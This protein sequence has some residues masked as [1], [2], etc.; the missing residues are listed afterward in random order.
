MASRSPEKFKG[1]RGPAPHRRVIAE[2]SKAKI[3]FFY[4]DGDTKFRAVKVCIHPRR[5][6]RMEA[7]ITELSAKVKLPFGVRSIFTP[8]GR[9]MITSLEK[10]ENGESYICSPMRHQARGLDTT[11]VMPPPR[12]YYDKPPSGTKQL[13]HLL[14]EFEFEDRSRY[15]G[16]RYP[17]RDARM[18]DAYNRAQP[19]KITVLKN[20]EPTVHHVVLINRRTA[21]MFEQILSDISGMFSMAVRKLYTVEGRRISNLSAMIN[22]PDVLVAAGREP[23]R[24]LAGFVHP[25]QDK[26][27]RMRTRMDIN[28][29]LNMRSTMDSHDDPVASRLKKRRDRLMKTKGNWKVWCT[30]NELPTAGTNAQVTITVYGHKGNTGPVPLGFP[31]K[32][33][34][35]PGQVDEFDLSMGTSIGEIYKI[36]VGHDNSGSSPEWFCDEV[37]MQD[38]DTSEMLVFPCRRWMSRDE[39]DHE[40]CREMPAIRKGEPHLPVIKYEVSVLTGD[41]W[42]AGTEANVYLTIYGDRGDSGVRQLYMAPGGT[43]RSESGGGPFKKGQTSHFTVEAVSLGHLKR[44]IVGHDGTVPG[45]GWYLERMLIQ[46]P[47]AKPHEVYHFYCGRWLDEGEDDGKIVRELKVQD[48][49]L[50]DILEKRNW[51]FEKWKFDSKNQ[52]MLMSML[53]GKALRIKADGTVDGLGEET[54]AG[55]TLIVSS[56]KPMVRLFTSLLNGNFHLAIDHGKVTGQGRGGPQCEFRIHVQSDRTVM[57]EGAKSPLQFITLS[58]TGKLGDSR[59]TLDKDPAKRFHVY[60]KGVLRHR[61]IVMLRTS[62]IQAISVDH[63]KS[64]FATGRCNK[65]AHFRCHKVDEGGVRMFESMIYPGFYIRLKDGKFDCNGSR[66]EDSHFM[67]EKHKDKGYFTIQANKQRGMYIGFTPKGAV[68]PTVDTGTNNIHIFPEV[69]EYGTSKKQ[70]TQEEKLTPISERTGYT[71]SPEVK[72]KQDFEEGDYRV[73]VSTDETM[74]NGQAVLQVYGDKGSTG[75]VVLTGPPNDGPSFMRGSTDEFKVNLAKLGKLFK[76]RLELKPRSQTKDPSWKVRSLVLVNLLTQEK[77][78]FDFN[79]WLSREKEDQSLVRELPVVLP[80]QEK[81]SLPV[82]T[83]FVSVFT[84]KDP[85]SETDALVYIN[86]YGDF[87][88]CGR[89]ELRKSNRPKMFAR[90]QSDTFELEAVHLGNLSRV[91]IGHEET[92]PGGGWFLDKVVVRE[93]KTANMEFVFACGRW[94]DSSMED[95]KLERILTVKEPAPS[96]ISPVRELSQ[97]PVLPP[98]STTPPRT[99]QVRHTPDTSE[100]EQTEAEVMAGS[101]EVIPALEDS[102]AAPPMEETEAITEDETSGDHIDDTLDDGGEESHEADEEEEGEE[103]EK[104]EEEEEQT[105]QED[106]EEDETEGEMEENKESEIEE[107]EEPGDEHVID[108]LMEEEDAPVLTKEDTKESFKKTQVSV[109]LYTHASSDPSMEDS[110]QLYLYGRDGHLGPLTLGSGRDGKFKPDS[111]DTISISLEESV[112]PLY[113]VRIGLA[114]NIFGCQWYL[115][116]LKLSEPGSGEEFDLDVGRW[117]SRQKEDCDVWRE[118]SI[119]RPQEPPL[120]VIIYT[121]EVHTSDLS[122]ADTTA[123]MFIT[124]FGQQGDSGQRRLYVTQTD[125]K[126]FSQGK[127]DRFTFEAVSLGQLN[128]VVIGHSDN[129]AGQGAHIDYVAVKEFNSNDEEV[130]T[131]FP[132]GRWLD[133]GQDDGQIVRELHPGQRPKEEPKKSSGE[134]LMWVTTAEDSSPAQGGKATIV[135]YGDKG[136]SD[137]IE[138]FAPSSTARLFEPANSDEFEVSTGEIGEIYKIRITREDRTEWKGWHLEEVKLEDKASGQVYIFPFDRWLS[139]DMGDG[140]LACELPVVLS[141]METLKVKRYEF[142]VTTGDHWAAE[143][144]AGVWVTLYGSQGDAGKRLLHKS[145]SGNKPFQR[146]AEDVFTVEAVDL[147][148]LQTMEI[149]HTGKGPGAGWYLEHITVSDMTDGTIREVF[150]CGRWLDEGEDDGKTCRLLRK[151]KLP[152]LAESHAVPT[153]TGGQ[154]RVRIRT[155][156]LPDAG[157]HAQVYLTVQGVKDMSHPIP[158][159]DGSLGMQHFQPGQEAEFDIDLDDHLGELTKIRLEHDGRNSDPAWHVDWVQL[160]H[161]NSG[162]DC[163]F[164]L[165]R[166]LAEDKGD[167]QMFRECGLESPGWMPA[168]VLR[169]II[170]I[171]TGRKANSGANGGICSVNLIGSHGDTGQQL[172]QR[173]LVR[174][175]DAMKEGAL[176]V[177]MI[178]AVSVGTLHSIRLGF[179]G[180]GRAKEWYIESV[181]VMESLWAITESVFTANCWLDDKDITAVNLPISNTCKASTLPNDISVAVLG[182]R[183][184]ESNGSWELWVWTSH[185][186]GAGSSDPLTLTLFGSI[187]PSPPFELNQNGEFYAGSCVHSKIQAGS[188]GDL[189]KIRLAFAEKIGNSSWFLDRI[190][191]KDCDSLQEFNFQ[192]KNWILSSDVNQDGMVELP[193]IRPD[194][195]PLSE[196]VYKLK[197]ITGDLPCAET[198]AEVSVML[199]GEWGDSGHRCISKPVNGGE[200]FRRGQTD[201]FELHLLNLGRISHLLLGHGEH[202]R[203]KGWFAAHAALNFAGPDGGQMEAVFACNRWLDSG[204]DDRKTLRKFPAM[205]TITLKEVV[206]PKVRE[207][208]AGIWTVYIKMAASEKLDISKGSD[209]AR[210]GVSLV[211]YGTQ[212]VIGPVELGKDMTGRFEP[213]QTEVFKG[214]QLGDIGDLTKIRVSSGLEGDPDSCWAVE[215]VLMLDETTREKLKFDYSGSVGQ[216]GGDVRKERPVIRPG[217][218]VSPLVTYSVRVDT[219]DIADG[220]TSARVYVTIYGSQGDTGRRLLHTTSGIMP[221]SQGQ[222]QHFS[223]EAV[224]VGDLEKIVVTKGPGDSWMLNQMIVKAGQFGPVEHTFIWSNWVGNEEKR[225]EQV[226]VTLPVISTRPSTVAVP[227]SDFPDFPVTRGQWSVEVLTGTDGTSGDVNDVTIVFCGSK[228]ESTPVSLTGKRENT[229]Q[230]GTTEKFEVSLSEDV[231]DLIKMRI[232]FE[233]NLQPK[234]WHLKRIHFEDVDTKD[235]FWSSFA[236][237]IA[238]N[239][240]SDGWTEFPVVW[241][242]VFILPV[243]KYH[244]TVI[245]AD[246]PGAST[247]QVIIVKLDGQMGSTGYRRLQ[248]TTSGKLHFQ[249]GQTDSFVIE[250]VSLLSIDSITIGHNSGNPGDGWF[251]LQVTVKPENEEDPYVFVCNRWLDAGQDDGEIMRTL[252]PGDADDGSSA[253]TTAISAKKE[254]EQEEINNTPIEAVTVAPVASKRISLSPDPFKED[255]LDEAEWGKTPEEPEVGPTET[256]SETP[257]KPETPK[258]KAGHWLVF[259]V[260]APET[261]SWTEANVTLTVF[262]TNGQSGPILLESEDKDT[263]Q[264]GKTDQFDIFL[265]PEVIGHLKKIRLEHDNTGQS[266]GWRVSKLILENQVTEE[267]HEFNVDRWLSFEVEN[268]DIVYE[269]GVTS[270]DGLAPESCQYLIKTVTEAQENAGTEANVHITVV[271]SLG[272]SGRRYL[273]NGSDSNKKFLEGKTDSFILEAVDLGDL[274]KV[275]VGHDG[276]SEPD[277]AWGLQCVMV[278]KMDPHI[279][280]SS[281][282]PYGKWIADDAATAGVDIPVGQMALDSDSEESPRSILPVQNQ[283]TL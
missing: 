160:K 223:I 165:D 108:M 263:F 231:S 86:L 131:F 143:T 230:P 28:S 184:A 63:D 77:H 109:Q 31:D 87:G 163:L 3:C 246:S 141:G 65:A 193:A 104:M 21:Q 55:S 51:E 121:V 7:L 243:V 25:P 266:M 117:M 17:N 195:V 70:L 113:K 82:V 255:N 205:G 73:L 207:T 277:A 4:K 49:Y 214:V 183:I 29:R 210:Q 274:E 98:I 154:W 265:D 225:D 239:E 14:Q 83:Y 173:P 155:S 191:L 33:G 50:D 45:D 30:T 151:M 196:N 283:D 6:H 146:G 150:P 139:R 224:D 268:G 128:S 180:R 20:G 198:S 93:G 15:V 19:K 227:T 39:D 69:I 259:T 125:G 101:P 209:T 192:Y 245:T 61:G 52:V 88:D 253:L 273:K 103:D 208:S 11:K 8:R 164:T 136:K 142:L 78:T 262:G 41:L 124:L 106:E 175:M 60:A 66:N 267:K 138:L 94:F 36:R 168:P 194:I 228:G 84:G 96:K 189:F 166:W 222:K 56:K 149:E 278:R 254:E 212:K 130:E 204:V 179:E 221:F 167:G 186:D 62:N 34:F 97:H 281:V 242:G 201:E 12:W 238:V 95:R 129:Q 232:G 250:A 122:G 68:R 235:T 79:Q 261:D 199:I 16:R 37:R 206:S 47:D 182:H 256:K 177:Y 216:L 5:Y 241:P 119:S 24:T 147:A 58:D 81:E 111:I 188:I 264:A 40:I 43:A 176:D 67:V 148:E 107:T 116:K 92:R 202:G 22:G 187:G 59:S 260:T 233:D 54:D 85:G 282:F 135:V 170:L 145:L 162:F 226:E 185:K 217:T 80:G 105:N 244:V 123:A 133:S 57:L 2:P 75:P 276:G 153:E 35:K 213:G 118:L 89:R 27:S 76:A 220:G 32:S 38:V 174:S 26:E 169:Y 115:D 144:D 215:E 280:E 171:Q 229:F 72:R 99:P 270:Q 1:R 42:N 181:K 140:D 236:R 156:D 252:Y 158:L 74:E 100:F 248:D 134:Y 126:M 197:I 112:G 152:E 271:G 120:P 251:L 23:F 102:E 46:E 275:I 10:L 90:G 237:P 53:T 64:L 44:V 272:D 247:D 159:G 114:E 9:D 218:T 71:E 127:I 161:L 211:V 172:L 258:H 18:A 91:Q 249:Q 190:K 48:E 234:S 137:E 110:A 132:C 203:G 219:E 13:S 157:T 200:P 240:T 279:R 178:E 257:Q 269:A